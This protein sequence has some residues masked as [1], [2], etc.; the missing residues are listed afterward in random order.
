MAS[1]I[2]DPVEKTVE[3]SKAMTK[4]GP[5]LEEEYN[6][7]KSKKEKTFWQRKKE[8]LLEEGIE[9]NS[10]AELNPGVIKDG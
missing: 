2:R 3:Y 9:W 8:L 1:I 6:E 5:I 4:V 7:R 10:P